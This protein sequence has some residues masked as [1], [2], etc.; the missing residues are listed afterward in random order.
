[1]ARSGSHDGDDARSLEP[2]SQRPFGPGPDHGRR[3]PRLE[4]GSC[5]VAR[6]QESSGRTAEEHTTSEHGDRWGED[7]RGAEI[8]R[9]LWWCRIDDARREGHGASLA[10]GCR[11][12]LTA[13]CNLREWRE[14]RGRSPRWMTF[15]TKT[16]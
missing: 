8:E 5:S 10:G 1:M 7:H 3:S 14:H 12:G 9:H 6:A 15:V 2:P 16:P 11:D 4:N 13:V